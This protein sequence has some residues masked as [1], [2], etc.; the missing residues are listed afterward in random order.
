M[1]VLFNYHF[2]TFFGHLIALFLSFLTFS[3][4]SQSYNCHSAVNQ[5]ILK[6]GEK[7][8]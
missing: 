1:R 5:K 6:M 7:M 2:D 4:M 3:I 8:L